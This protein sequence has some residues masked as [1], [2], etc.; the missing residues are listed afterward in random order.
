[1]NDIDPILID[2]FYAA[3]SARH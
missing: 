3:L 2:L 1:M